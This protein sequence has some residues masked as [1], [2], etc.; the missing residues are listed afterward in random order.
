MD[1]KGKIKDNQ[2]ARM[3]I[4]ELCARG[5]LELVQLHN[6]KLAK[7]KANYTFFMKYTKI[8]YKWI[9]ELKMP[10]GYVSNIARCANNDKGSL[11]GIKSHDCH[12][13]MEFLLPIAFRSLPE[14]VWSALTELSRVFKDL[15]C[16]T[17][18][19]DDLVRME[20][21]IP[22]IICKL[23]RIFPPSFLIQWNTLSFI[24]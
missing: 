9:S 14:F 1:V 19:M 6:G 24:F 7:P 10:D 3:D 12:V 22:I 23:E 18:R 5:D 13:F 21:N 17:L 16:N 11:Y 15:C 8:I 20:E 2:N 4:V